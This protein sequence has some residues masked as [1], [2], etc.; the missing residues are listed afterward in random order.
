[1]TPIAATYRLQLHSGFPFD[2]AAGIADYL[3]DLGISHAYCSPYL[4]AAPGSTH[5]YDVIDPSKPNDELGGEE[6]FARFDSALKRCGLGQ[7]LDIVPN[8]MAISS[9][10]NSW[11]A[12]VLENGPSSRYA[13][14]FDV[15]WDPPEA[16]LRNMVLL[17][18][19]ADHYGRV[20]DAGELRVV[21]DGAAFYVTYFENRLPVSPSALGPLLSRAARDARSAMLGFLADAFNDLPQPTVV[22]RAS[23]R[24]RH[25]DKAIL[26]EQLQRLL[27]DEPAT[28]AALDRAV[29]ALNTDS[30]DLHA[31]LEMQNYRLAWWKSAGRDLGY[32]RFF[33]INT[34]VAL[35]MEDEHV[36]ADTHARVL[37]WVSEGIIDGLR[38]DHP[39]GLRD[40][41]AYL[42]RLRAAAPHAWIVVEKIVEPGE[43]L[44][45]T[46]PAAGT[47]GYD[48]LNRVSG[49]FI[50]PSGEAPLTDFYTEFTGQP[51]DYTR[52][53]HEKKMY[54][55][56][57]VL[58]SDVNRLTDLLLQ[59]CERHRRHRD[60]SRHDLTDALREVIAWF[61]VYRTYVRPAAGAVS[62]ADRRSVDRAITAATAERP[63]IETTLFDFIRSLLLLEIRGLLEGELVARF[64]QLTGPAM[65]KGVEDTAFYVFNRFV[66]LNEVGG[67]P[68]RFGITVDEFHD[69]ALETQ[70]QWP[71]TMLSTSTHDTKR[72]EDV[73]ARLAVLSERPKEWISAVR[74]WSQMVEQHRTAEWPDRNTEYLF[75]QTLVGA[76]PISVDRMVAYMEKAAR[77]AKVHTS[78]TS[79]NDAYDAALKTFVRG[80]FMDHA[81]LRDVGTFVEPLV[82]PGWIN[83]LSQTLIKLTAP[84]IPDVYQGTEL[85]SFY[86]VD[87]DN[88]RPVDYEARRRALAAIDGIE[89]GMLW[90]RADE[91][92]PKMWVVREALALRRRHAGAF[93][94]DGGYTPVRA[95]G[96]AASHV[97]G[98]LRAGAVMT[99][100]PRLSAGEQCDW[101]ATSVAL[102]PGRWRNVLSGTAHE[103]GR[104]SLAC[105]WRDFPVALLERVDA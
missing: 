51:A 61:P 73:R 5:G 65:A 79:P 31:L 37:Q 44:P 15:D 32:R 99:L 91:G 42:E 103:S 54:V 13:S 4:Q 46:W 23:V 38:I 47:T 94:A 40:P 63:D 101:A 100:V 81:F 67:D 69:A 90:N 82:E 11:W 83:S 28:A 85:W 33:D 14:Y 70:A 48:F 105:V 62:P 59:I 2:A 10:A 89:P 24:R 74:R 20:L 95:H 80:A 43:H 45:D 102:P 77:E 86:L 49:L 19:L 104:V 3:K 16:R 60:Y 88:R 27:N 1:M 71:Q 75:Y 17:P 92:L 72:G 87:P 18:V 50:D 96:S 84:G 57:E 64:Q 55:L 6:G 53:V 30:D 76:W 36:F 93:G 66:A 56:R 9:P 35:R 29:D 7:V 52:I 26:Q 34:L 8:H 39:D 25:R 21:R 68:S 12:D 22:D 41:Q 97:I 78:W 98:F 58:G